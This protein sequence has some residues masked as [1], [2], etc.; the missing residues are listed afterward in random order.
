MRHNVFNMYRITNL[1]IY[2]VIDGPFFL[3]KNEHGNIF[4]RLY[5]HVF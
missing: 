5:F 3:F 2:F 1:F 4:N